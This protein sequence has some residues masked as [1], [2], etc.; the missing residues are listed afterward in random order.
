MPGAFR[1]YKKQE[2]FKT[3]SRSA[4][5]RT[6]YRGSVPSRPECPLGGVPRFECALMSRGQVFAATV[7]ELLSSIEPSTAPHLDAICGV[8][9]EGP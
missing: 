8:S 4:E 7:L 6:K 1:V 2:K 9:S 5:W 3:P